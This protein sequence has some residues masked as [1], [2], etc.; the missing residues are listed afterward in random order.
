MREHL[1][2]ALFDLKR[3]AIREFSKLANA[4]AGC[5]KLTLGEPDFR[6]PAPISAQV[7]AS[8]S[9]GETHYID[10]NGTLELR[11][12]IAA[13]EQKHGLNYA[14]DEI[15]LTAGAT[16]ALFVAL[17]G[18]LEPNDEVIIPQPAFVLYEEQVKMCRGKVVPLDTSADGFQIRAER[19]EPLISART[20]AIVL[21]SPNNPTGAVYDTESLDAVYHAVRDRNIFII[22][23]DVYRD[24][25]Y[26]GAFHSFAERRELKEKILYI[27]SFSKPYAMTGWRM[28]W[29]IADSSI[30]ER[31]ELV[32]QFTVVS[33]PAPFQRACIT[34]LE[35]DIGAF[36]DE[37]RARRDYCVKRLTAMGLSFPRPDGAFYLFPKVGGDSA[38]FCRTLIDEAGVALTP[39]IC[40]GMEGYARLSYACSMHDLQNGLD[41]LEKF[42]K[43]R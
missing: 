38:A 36:R 5:I 11:Q 23:D 9:A 25:V 10:N 4:K 30:K 15:I 13:H 20:K 17:F 40:F 31:L 29:L 34:A 18:I 3:S 21:N 28:G 39:G 42:L 8:L 7:T 35:Q 41:R 19:L 2:A 43:T 27:Q 22:C 6:T 12:A 37:Y 1:N 14:P 33:T 16:E 24:L 32:H 26:D